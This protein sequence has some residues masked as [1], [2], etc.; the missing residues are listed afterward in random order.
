MALQVGPNVREPHHNAKQH[1]LKRSLASLFAGRALSHY[2]L[3]R[4]TTRTLARQFYL[5]AIPAFTV[6][7]VT[8]MLW[9]RAA[10]ATSEV[11][12]FYNM[13]SR[14]LACLVNVEEDASKL[15][16]RSEINRNP[17]ARAR[18]RGK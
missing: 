5:G 8:T 10:L 17:F 1:S 12:E 14:K 11:R 3:R 9:V 15:G 13:M 6:Y 18:L 7:G 16:I 4:Y 2:W